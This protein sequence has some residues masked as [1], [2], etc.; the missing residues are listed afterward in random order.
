MCPSNRFTTYRRIGRRQNHFELALSLLTYI[1]IAVIDQRSKRAN[2]CS[3][4]LRMDG[5]QVRGYTAPHTQSPEYQTSMN[6]CEMERR[7]LR[8]ERNYNWF[9]VSNW[10]L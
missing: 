8:L 3:R 10:L 1:S 6:P 9:A 5:Q 7:V 4:Q 2:A